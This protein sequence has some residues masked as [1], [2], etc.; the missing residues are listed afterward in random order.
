M[1]QSKSKTMATGV[2]LERLMSEPARTM[3]PAI[4][5]LTKAQGYNSNFLICQLQTGLDDICDTP[6]AAQMQIAHPPIW[7]LNILLPRTRITERIANASDPHAVREI[8]QA[9]KEAV[10][11]CV[12]FE[13]RGVLGSGDG[14]TLGD[15]RYRLREL[16]DH[17]N[18]AV[19]MP[20]VILLDNSYK[21]ASQYDMA[22]VLRDWIDSTPLP[23]LEETAPRPV[24]PRG[25]GYA[26]SDDDEP[27][28]VSYQL[29]LPNE[30]HY[31]ASDDDEPEDQEAEYLELLRRE[32]AMN[33]ELARLA[34]VEEVLK[35]GWELLY[36]HEGVV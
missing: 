35:Q 23:E 28:I 20:F 5:Q 14:I 15:L 9:E 21:L 32:Y 6:E 36:D 33:V 22:P 25:I 27:E 8:V 29:A 26:S 17:P 11:D 31:A 18:T 13:R 2:P 3:H 34:E 24:L 12:S 4:Q 1:N 16:L 10:P 7:G 30:V 19:N